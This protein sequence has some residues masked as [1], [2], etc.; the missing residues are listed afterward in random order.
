MARYVLRFFFDG[1][2]GD[3][4]W[5][6]NDAAIEKYGYPVSLDDLCLSEKTIAMAE[7]IMDRECLMSQK[8]PD[9]CGVYYEFSAEEETAHRKDVDA[10]LRII[11]DELGPDFEIRDEVQLDV[12]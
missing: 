11:R 6:H 12:S 2:T 9:V 5:S 4:L 1:C 8:T 3:C 10:L 7:K